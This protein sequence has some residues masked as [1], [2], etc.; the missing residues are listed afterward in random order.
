MRAVIYERYGGPEVLE[1]RDW[2]QPEAQ[3]GEVVVAVHAAG[4]NP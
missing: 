2:P 1:L 3:S 4:V